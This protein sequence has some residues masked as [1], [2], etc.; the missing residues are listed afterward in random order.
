M[1]IA[2]RTRV[3]GHMARRLR[4][5]D[6]Y[7]LKEELSQWRTDLEIQVMERE[8][9]GGLVLGFV[10]GLRL[11]ARLIYAIRKAISHSD[12]EVDWGHLLT[13]E[14]NS[15]SPECDIIIH[16]RG[17]KQR[18]NGHSNSIMD[19]KFIACQNA[20]AVISCKS[21]L[22]SVDREYCRKMNSYV[23]NVLL[24]AECCKPKSVNGLKRS[25]LSAGYKGFWYLYKFDV[26]TSECIHEEVVWEDFLDFLENLS[27]NH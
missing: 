25:A 19:F 16:S 11:S 5:E 20:V 8:K 18:W 3:S 13:P 14:G 10:R 2:E 23:D 7:S 4:L 27:L 24:F 17:C 22:K 6:F 12:L 1:P 21:F 26:E 9:R 15:C